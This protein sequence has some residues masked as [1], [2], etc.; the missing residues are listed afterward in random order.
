MTVQWTDIDG[1]VYQLDNATYV[2]QV[3]VKA[4]QSPL[5]PSRRSHPWRLGCLPVLYALLVAV[6]CAEQ[7][8]VDLG[9]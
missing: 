4:Q 8:G 3:Q 6:D 7:G 1:S 9:A 2:F 5:R